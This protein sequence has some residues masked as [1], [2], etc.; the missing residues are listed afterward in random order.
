MTNQEKF[1]ALVSPE[2]TKT[3]EKNRWRIANRLW[4]NESQEIAMKILDKLEALDWSQKDLAEKMG[5][6]PQYINKIVKGKENLTLE[7]LTHLQILL[8]IP[9]LATYYEAQARDT[10]IYVLEET[11]ISPTTFVAQ[12]PQKQSK[13]IPMNSNLN[14]T[15]YS[16][17]KIAYGE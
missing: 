8:D 15:T 12:Y 13:V 6:S 7:T 10:E 1:L 14:F 16:Y 4:L 2:A 9:L 3:L 5:V 17:Q 11:T